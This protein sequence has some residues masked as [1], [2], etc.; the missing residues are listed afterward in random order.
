M[1]S[2][3]ELNAYSESR[4]SQP[5]TSNAMT[6]FLYHAEEET[7]PGV[8]VSDGLQAWNTMVKD[9]NCD[10][11]YMDVDFGKTY[12]E[13]IKCTLSRFGDDTKVS[14]AVDTPEGWGTLQRALDKLRKWV[15]KNL[16]RFNKTKWKVLHL[17]QGN[18]WYQYRLGDEQIKSRLAEKGLGELVMRDCM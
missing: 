12:C 9:L 17:T 5:F 11:S 2:L 3:T 8:L 7:L 18:L 15:P 10:F 1:E 6:T 4:D 16:L 13:V 14:D